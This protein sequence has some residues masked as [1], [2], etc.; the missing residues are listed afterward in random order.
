MPVRVQERHAVADLRR[1]DGDTD[2]QGHSIGPDLSFHLL[3]SC[4][5]Q[6]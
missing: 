3:A 1:V 5:P 4:V 6:L 2:L